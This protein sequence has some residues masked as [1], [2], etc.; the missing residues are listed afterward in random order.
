[1]SAHFHASL[2]VP[3]TSNSSIGTVPVQQG[4]IATALA[5]PT[6]LWREV[7]LRR[8][9]RRLEGLDDRMLGDIGIGRADIEGVVR[10][11]RHVLPYL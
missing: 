1:M 6:R 2:K 3:A 9:T 10:H 7:Q 5:V 4:W 11:G 8:A